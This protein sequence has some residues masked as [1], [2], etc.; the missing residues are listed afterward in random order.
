LIFGLVF[1][2]RDFEVGRNVNCEESNVSPCQFR[3]GLIYFSVVSCELK[4]GD[5]GVATGKMQSKSV[6]ITRI[7]PIRSTCNPHTWDD[8]KH[9]VFVF[10]VR[11]QFLRTLLCSV[12]SDVLLS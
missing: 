8:E 2:S 3:M 6:R 10:A 4:W 9:M 7:L 1:V 5:V 11:Q 12:Y